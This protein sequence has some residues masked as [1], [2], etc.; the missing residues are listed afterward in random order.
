MKK[1]SQ[2]KPYLSIES[3]NYRNSNKLI[4]LSVAGKIILDLKLKPK[5]SKS[6]IDALF[7]ELVIA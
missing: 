2:L 1:I 6:L 3:L 7:S 5:P 4:S